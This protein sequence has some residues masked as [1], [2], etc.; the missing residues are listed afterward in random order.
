MECV[1]LIQAQPTREVWYSPFLFF[2]YDFIKVSFPYSTSVALA[3][4]SIIKAL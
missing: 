4:Y 3:H 2:F 1:F